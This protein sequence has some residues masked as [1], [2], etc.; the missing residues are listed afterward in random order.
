MTNEKWIITRRDFMR[1]TVGAAIGASLG[2]SLLGVE[3]ALG[4][5]NKDRLSLVT[6]VRNE[7][8]MDA[9]GSSIN[10]K[11]LREML[12]QAVM[13]TTGEKNAKAA[14]LQLVKPKDIV[15]L[16]PTRALNATHTELY[17]ALEASLVEAG[18][19]KNNISNVQGRTGS[20]LV[21]G[22]TALISLPALKAHWLTGIG[23]VI[24]NYIMFSGRPTHY[25][26]EDSDKLGEIW[27][28]PNVKGKTRLVLVDALHPLCDKGPQVDPRYK[29]VYNGL[30]AGTDP[31]AVEAVCVRILEEKRRL[32]HGEPW[33][34]SPP[35]LCL[36]AADRVYHLGTSK[37]AEIRIKQVGWAKDHLLPV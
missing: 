14:W 10:S 32:L 13:L 28:Q 16:V 33:P 27:H 34:L 31:V 37:L 30:I 7:K 2:T 1:G 9:E 5:E 23:T 35:P 12:D 18:I 24:K 11:I 8:V 21:D 29:W 36:E 25:H 6:V 3:R 20:S 26:G 22:C 19:P 4:V 17:D 15:G